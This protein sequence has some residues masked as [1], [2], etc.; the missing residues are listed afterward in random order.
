MQEPPQH[1]ASTHGV[2]TTL[3][4]IGGKWKPLILLRLG[5]HAQQPDA[6]RAAID[7]SPNKPQ[8]NKG[9][10][11]PPFLISNLS[12]DVNHRPLCSAA[13]CRG[14]LAPYRLLTSSCTASWIT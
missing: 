2:V 1:T 10:T 9:G 14:K 6:E 7:R 11:V 8:K 5:L 3:Q 13:A 4:A 12:F